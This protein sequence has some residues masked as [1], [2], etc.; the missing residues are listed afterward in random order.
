MNTEQMLERAKLDQITLEAKRIEEQLVK[1]ERYH[2]RR[3]THDEKAQALRIG[4][5]LS[6]GYEIGDASWVNEGLATL[7]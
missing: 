1:Y 3:L 4:I 7:N 2:G 5:A 6:D